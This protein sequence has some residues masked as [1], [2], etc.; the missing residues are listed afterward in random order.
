MSNNKVPQYDNNQVENLATHIK[1][2]IELLGE[3]PNREGLAK[4]PQR[5]AKALIDNTSGYHSNAEML[6]KQALFN[7]E[8]DEM[9]IVKDIEF[10][11]LCEHHVLPFYGTISI[12]YI[13]DGQIVGL[14]K[15][16][17]V[18][19]TFARRLQVQERLT[20]QVCQSVSDNIKNKGVIVVC[21]AAHMCMKMRGIEKQATTTATMQYCG[22]FEKIEMQNQF[23]NLLN[24]KKEV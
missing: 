11:S 23:F 17:R 6:I 3:D 2:I 14:S 13:P 16:A 4:T 8:G 20:Q 15:L 12:G 7:H 18:V 24:S 21:N 1:A 19:E 9:V 5:A 22:E 10:Y